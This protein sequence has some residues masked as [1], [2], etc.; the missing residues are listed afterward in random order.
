MIPPE[1][2]IVFRNPDIQPSEGGLRVPKLAG[3]LLGSGSKFLG[4]KI[5]LAV[6]SERSFIAPAI[7]RRDFG[8]GGV[9]SPRCKEP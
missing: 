9:A 5:V 3:I 6:G 4:S 8:I 1:A 7:S 2:G